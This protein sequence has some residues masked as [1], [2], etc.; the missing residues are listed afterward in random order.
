MGKIH[1]Q[2]RTIQHR[3]SR[4]FLLP[5]VQAL[6]IAVVRQAGNHHVSAS[7][8]QHLCKLDELRRTV[9]Q[10]MH[11]DVN[12]FG[13]SPVVQNDRTAFFS[14]FRRRDRSECLYLGN[15]RLEVFHWLRFH[16]QRLKR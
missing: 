6:D 13:F 16:H 15:G 3:L 12:V 10:T 14:D 11:Q 4:H 1:R 9:R 8:M 7:G 2:T 5:I